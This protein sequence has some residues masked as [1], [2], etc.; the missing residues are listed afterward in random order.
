MGR[1]LINRHKRTK[2]PKDQEIV[3]YDLVFENP[4]TR[5][6]VMIPL[7]KDHRVFASISQTRAWEKPVEEL[8][9]GE[10]VEGLLNFIDCPLEGLE[11]V[12]DKSPTYYEAKTAVNIINSAGRAIPLTRYLLVKGLLEL[13]GIATSVDRTDIE[14]KLLKENKKDFSS[15]E[16]NIMARYLY[17]FLKQRCM[18]AGIGCVAFETVRDGYLGGTTLFPIEWDY[19]KFFTE[20]NPAFQPFANGFEREVVEQPDGR[21]VTHI[22]PLKGSVC[23]FYDVYVQKRRKLRLRLYHVQQEIQAT[24]KER[25]RFDPNKILE[26]TYET[27]D[28]VPELRLLFEH[29]DGVDSQQI[30]LRVKSKTSIKRPQFPVARRKYEHSKRSNLTVIENKVPS[31]AGFRKFQDFPLDCINGLLHDIFE[32]SVL[33]L[34]RNEF[35]SRKLPDCWIEDLTWLVLYQDGIQNPFTTGIVKGLEREKE[36]AAQPGYRYVQRSAPVII[37]GRKVEVHGEFED[38]TEEHVRRVQA[39][40]QLYELAEKTRYAIKM[41]QF[42]SFFGLSH[43]DYLAFYECFKRTTSALPNKYW[44]F[45]FDLYPETHPVTSEPLNIPLKKGE[46]PLQVGIRAIKE[47]EQE[48]GRRFREAQEE[49]EKVRNRLF[50]QGYTAKFLPWKFFLDPYSACPSEQCETVDIVRCIEDPRTMLGAIHNPNLRQKYSFAF[51]IKDEVEE[52]LTDLRIST[53]GK[54]IH[55]NNYIS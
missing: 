7:H 44:R 53:I 3:G 35:M 51:Y 50:P 10:D 52:I 26:R 2:V 1:G 13:P 11:S 29:Y 23:F 22:R 49:L 19:F 55:P 18:Q 31:Y 34:F 42:D 4:E 27:A 9:V 48:L 45:L 43:G 39:R 5:E 20:I 12:L 25:K 54:L 40:N 8:K 6:E 30:R 41:G 46:D 38:Q 14:A 24:M 36:R 21:K 33:K 47:I 37:K 28:I 15:Q 16:Y 32:Y 17:N